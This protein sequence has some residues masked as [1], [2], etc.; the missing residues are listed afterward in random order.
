MPLSN[1]QKK[2]FFEKELDSM[3]VDKKHWDEILTVNR[4]K[5]LKVF[6]AG[7]TVASLIWLMIFYIYMKTGFQP[8]W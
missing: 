2:H 5:L 3:K 6:L 7:A 1:N 8:V 4:K